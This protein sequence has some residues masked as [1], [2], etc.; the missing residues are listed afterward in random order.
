MRKV[1]RSMPGCK[2]KIELFRNPRTKEWCWRV[3][4]ASN[5]KQ[6]SRASETYKRKREC[7][8]RLQGFLDSMACSD[9]QLEEMPL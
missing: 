3:R 4:Y 8:K 6:H 1:L 7:Y 2:Y 9:Y 5:G